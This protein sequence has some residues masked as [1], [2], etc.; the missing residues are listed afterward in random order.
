MKFRQVKDGYLVRLEKGEEVIA[1]LAEFARGNEI[2]SGFIT[3]MGAVTNAT[4]GLYDIETK[5]YTKKTFKDDLELGNLTGNISWMHDTGEP[6]VHAH[7]TVSDCSLNA[8]TG[9]LFEA[10]VLVTLEVYVKVFKEKLIREEDPEAG[11]SFWQL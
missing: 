4:L 9:H 1:S 10:T 5:K 11:F 6:F 7:V 8:F 2:P 3:G